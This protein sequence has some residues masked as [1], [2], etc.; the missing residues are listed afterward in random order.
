[1]SCKCESCGEQY[2]VDILV[3]NELWEEIRPERKTDSAGLLCGKCII[4]KLEKMGYGGFRLM[5]VC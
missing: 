5:R 4:K 3:S 1:M 2:K